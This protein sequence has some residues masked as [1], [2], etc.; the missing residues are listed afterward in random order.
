M[1]SS[2]MLAISSRMRQRI[3]FVECGTIGP[4]MSMMIIF[5]KNKSVQAGRDA[6]IVED[7][8]IEVRR[9]VERKNTC[10]HNRV[11]VSSTCPYSQYRYREGAPGDFW[12]LS[13]RKR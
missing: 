2:E 9:I 3:A 7:M 13:M 12:V 1:R 5:K 4:E 10:G 6:C 11:Y 8:H